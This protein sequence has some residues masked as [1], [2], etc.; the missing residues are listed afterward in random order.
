MLFYRTNLPRA[1][2]F[3]LLGA[4]LI[5]VACERSGEVTVL[6]DSTWSR[7]GLEA[8]FLPVDPATLAAG[9]APRKSA[10]Q[11]DSI[12]TLSTLED[13]SAKLDASFLELRNELNAESEALARGDRRSS[14]YAKRY[15]EFR[16][17][18][19]R[20][21]SLRAARD[22][23]LEKAALYR[24]ALATV[25]PDSARLVKLS[26]EARRRIDDAESEGRRARSGRITDRRVS[27]SLEPGEWWVG[28][29][30]ADRRPL[31]FER[32]SVAAG[33]RDTVVWKR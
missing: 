5:A 15:D 12:A 19:S 4:L 32:V 30:E 31:R 23:L 27:V 33:R 2:R 1:R 22:K 20:A 14:E 13:S 8:V 6:I 29:G 11:A 28:V 18:A 25:L 10:A 26:Q 21:E 7:E 16:P 17:R 24:R 9:E 3:I